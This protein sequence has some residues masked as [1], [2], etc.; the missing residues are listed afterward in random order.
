MAKA[1]EVSDTPAK[2]PTDHR[3]VAGQLIADETAEREA[4][5]AAAKAS[6][7]KVKPDADGDIDQRMAA[8]N[9]DHVAMGARPK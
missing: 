5:Q 2:A 8:L 9:A 6:A 7:A 1:K 4:K 3:L